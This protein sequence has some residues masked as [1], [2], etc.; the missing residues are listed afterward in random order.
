MET[1]IY[2]HTVSHD[3]SV[4]QGIY[5]LTRVINAQEAKVFFDEAYNYGHAIFQDRM[6]YKYELV[7]NGAEYQLVKPQL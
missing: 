1:I 2:G 6:G 4:S 7:H 5:F 3:D